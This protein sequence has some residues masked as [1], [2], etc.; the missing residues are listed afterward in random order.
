MV[1]PCPQ[2]LGQMGERFQCTSVFL[3]SPCRRK[4]QVSPSLKSLGDGNMY[5][6]I[7]RY[8]YIYN[9]TIY[10]YLYIWGNIVLTNPSSSKCRH[11]RAHGIIQN[12]NLQP[13]HV[14]SPAW[15]ARK[16]LLVLHQFSIEFNWSR[17]FLSQNAKEDD[18][19]KSRIT[20]KAW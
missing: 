9:Y 10:M 8:I 13:R 19:Y 4:R 12:L 18:K 3:S 7:Y 15:S 16:V 11:G 2:E 20:L 17:P 14:R 5:I 1:Q 6:Y